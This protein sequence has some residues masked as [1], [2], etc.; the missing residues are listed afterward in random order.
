MKKFTFVAILLFVFSI[1]PLVNNAQDNFK[2]GI[3]MGP[4]F[5]LNQ[6]KSNDYSAMPVGFSQSGFSLSFDGDYYFIHRLAVSA[7]FNFGLSSMDK[8][9][10]DDWLDHQMTGYLSA[11][12]DNNLYSVDYWQWSAPLIGLKYNYPIVINKLYVDVA[13]FTGLSIVQTPNQNLK[14][15]DEDNKRAIFSENV[16]SKTTA[17]PFM[18]DGGLRY[19]ATNNI[20][21]KFMASYFQSKA[22]FD[23]VNY[24]MKE[25]ATEPD[26]LQTKSYN[27][28]VQTLSFNIGIIYNL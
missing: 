6:F 19:V 1:L 22:N 14:I 15:I 9:A 2:V 20:Q 21:V 13:G 5:P 12:T 28:P 25:N 18:F 27:L 3:S 4:V 7:R 26:L 8:V 23:H 11:N 17:L 24:I 10:V 16:D